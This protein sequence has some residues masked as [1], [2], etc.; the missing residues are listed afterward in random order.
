MFIQKEIFNS[1]QKKNSWCSQE[2]LKDPQDTDNLLK[3]LGDVRSINLNHKSVDQIKLGRPSKT[4]PL[5]G[6]GGG[7]VD[8]PPAKKNQLF[9]DKIEK[10]FSINE[11]KKDREA[12]TGPLGLLCT[13]RAGISCSIDC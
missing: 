8:P 12:T 11:A 3:H 5:L 13:F 7:G 6:G 9:S 10:I 4:C 1:M 2:N